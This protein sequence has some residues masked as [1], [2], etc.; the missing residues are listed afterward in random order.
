M[1]AY[2]S[3]VTPAAGQTRRIEVDAESTEGAAEI[4]RRRH[5]G[6][7]YTRPRPVD[8]G[9]RYTPPVISEEALA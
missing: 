1:S 7:D 4:I 2:L 5:P 9:L 8:D 6:C 3:W